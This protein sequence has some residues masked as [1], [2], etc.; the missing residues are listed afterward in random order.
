MTGKLFVIGLTG[1]TGAGKTLVADRWRE[2]GV[3]V[4]DSDQIA[5]QVVAPGE[6]ALAALADA[7]G[8]D[9]LLPDGT[10]NRAELARRAFSS[11]QST[12]RLN[13]LTHPAVLARIRAELTRLEREGCRLAAMDVPLLFE[14]GLDALC[15]RTAAVLATPEN[16]ME[17]IR[18]RDGLTT[19]QAA[20]RMAAQPDDGFYRA[21]AGRIIEN[22]GD[23]DALR[24][25]ADQL[26]EEYR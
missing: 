22:D 23:P 14:S 6:P 3:P 19:E 18:R 11:P 21:R 20:A 13:A 9:I 7:F 17:R 1:P 25:Q 4:I 15:D 16:R 8:E 10:L 5:R 12:A 24:R 26:L 2:Q